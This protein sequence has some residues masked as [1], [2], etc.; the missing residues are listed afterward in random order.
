MEKAVLKSMI[1][2]YFFAVLKNIKKPE[3][4]KRD[5]KPRFCKCVISGSFFLFKLITNFYLSFF[6]YFFHSSISLLSWIS[7]TNFF[8][9]LLCIKRIESP[10]KIA[11]TISI[12]LMIP[13]T[14]KDIRINIVEIIN[15]EFRITLCGK[16]KSTIILHQQ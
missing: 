14:E 15:P 13:L 3:S 9:N 11:E 6:F 16:M 4:L 7:S 10:N 8:S 5:E 12:L 2:N 1:Q